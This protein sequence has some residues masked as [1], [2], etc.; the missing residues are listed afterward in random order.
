MGKEQKEERDVERRVEESLASEAKEV[1]GRSCD[2]KRG[3]DE[4][5]RGTHERRRGAHSSRW[6]QVKIPGKD[7]EDGRRIFDILVSPHHLGEDGLT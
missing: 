3:R 2:T 7:E 6:H 1:W 5:A 4:T